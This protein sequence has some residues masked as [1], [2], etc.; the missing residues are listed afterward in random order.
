M[1]ATFLPH[2]AAASWNIGNSKRQ[3]PH[4]EAQTLATTG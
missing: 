4:Q 2:F 1:K 3:G